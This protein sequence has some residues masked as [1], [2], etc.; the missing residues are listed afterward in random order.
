[1]SQPE[2]SREKTAKTDDTI[3]DVDPY[4]EEAATEQLLGPDD[5]DD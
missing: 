2:E 1:M 4:A 3:A 5:E